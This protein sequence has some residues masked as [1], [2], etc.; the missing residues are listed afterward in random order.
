MDQK[1]D[2]AR[3][4][5]QALAHHVAG[6]V[7]MSFAVGRPAV[8][9]AIDGPY[10]DPGYAL[11]GDGRKL[12][13]RRRFLIAMAGH[14]AETR[15]L[16]DAFGLFADTA[17]ERLAF[18]MLHVMREFEALGLR[19]MGASALFRGQLGRVLGDLLGRAAVWDRIVDVAEALMARRSLTAVELA[20]L[21]P[22]EVTTLGL[23]LLDE[24]RPQT[25]ADPACC[26]G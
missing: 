8:S 3:D 21:V 1:R 24:T 19:G 6:H 17:N 5:M 23:K 22:A 26:V 13:I 16:G 18:D 12:T 9:A 4:P 10:D 20:G 7:V 15:F 2:L 14:Q 11:P 25:E